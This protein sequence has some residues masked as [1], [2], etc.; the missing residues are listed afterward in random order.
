MKMGAKKGV[1]QE[2]ENLD[3]VFGSSPT[4][5]LVKVDTKG[6]PDQEEYFLLTDVDLEKLR[7]RTESSPKTI[8]A[9]KTG[10][11]AD[12]LD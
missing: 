3:Q 11:L 6:L 10:W 1:M 8:A 5:M 2:V 12:Q 7:R 9:N 4:Y